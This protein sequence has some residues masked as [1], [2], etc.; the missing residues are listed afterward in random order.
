MSPMELLS[1]LLSDL[2]AGKG[3]IPLS[4]SLKEDEEVQRLREEISV[5]QARNSTLQIELDRAQ[6]LFRCESI[7]N[8][9]LVDLC[10]QHGIKLD[11]SFF[12]RPYSET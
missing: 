4:V 9:Q 6:Y 12:A 2:A 8:N 5:L 7:L 1:S 3:A 10:R 11:S